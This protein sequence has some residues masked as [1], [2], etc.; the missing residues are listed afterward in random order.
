MFCQTLLNIM[1]FLLI[2]PLF[3]KRLDCNLDVKKQKILQKDRTKI[4]FESFFIAKLKDETTTD[5]AIAA[6]LLKNLNFSK[7]LRHRFFGKR[8]S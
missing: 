2:E 4:Q 6:C 8:K 7:I 3:E 5:S 1:A